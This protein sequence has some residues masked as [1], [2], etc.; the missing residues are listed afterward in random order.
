M[1]S[2]ENE[3]AADDFDD[4]E[5]HHAANANSEDDNEPTIPKNE[6]AQKNVTS[7]Q[8][9]QKNVI[10]KKKAGG[11]TPIGNDVEYQQSSPSGQ[12]NNN[13]SSKDIHN[14]GQINMNQRR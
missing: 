12:L 5:D 2:D 1:N 4:N 8:R 14:R 11:G 6:S 10:N 3:Y 13:S 7:N 9:K